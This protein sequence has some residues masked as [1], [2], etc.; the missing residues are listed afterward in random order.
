MSMIYLPSLFT[1]HMILQ[2]GM[3]IP[4]WGWGEAGQQVK[5]SVGGQ[6]KSASVG[7]NQHWQVTL[8]P[9]AVGPPLIMTVSNGDCTITLNNTGY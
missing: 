9:L 4:V 5:V 7:Q 2:R 3:A 8:D 1:D 6:T